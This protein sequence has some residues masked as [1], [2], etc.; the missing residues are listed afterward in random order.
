MGISIFFVRDNPPKNSVRPKRTVTIEVLWTKNSDPIL[1][2]N[3][4]AR[5]VI[6]NNS[7]KFWGLIFMFES[8]E[9]IEYIMY[10]LIKGI[11]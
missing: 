6:N 11:K 1:P 3:S 2:I 4:W 5:P 9:R 7:P 8:S 10:M